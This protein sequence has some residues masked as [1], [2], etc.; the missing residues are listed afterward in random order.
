MESLVRKSS[1]PR[2]GLAV[3]VALL[4]AVPV[5]L[6]AEDPAVVE[7][8]K[9]YRERVEPICKTSASSNSRILKGVE[10]EVKRGDL[11]PAGKRFIRASSAFGKAVRKIAAVPRPDPYQTTLKKWVGFLGEEKQWL[12][13][14]G[15]ALK[16][17]KEAQAETYA[18]KLDRANKNA[19]RV[20]IDFEF[21][22]C[23]LESGEFL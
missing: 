3:A 7:A 6:A 12:F 15:Q 20:V 19:N 18:V 8:R 2:L 1:L 5:A 11:V 10:A 16:A 17:K 21:R 4:V 14:I 13:K 23:R 22:H 9:A